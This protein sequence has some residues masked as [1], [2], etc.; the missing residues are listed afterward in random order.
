V[1]QIAYG[2]QVDQAA[3]KRK[4]VVVVSSDRTFAES[5]RSH[6]AREF[7]VL[8]ARDGGEAAAKAQVVPIDVAVV[9]LGAPLLGMSALSRMK[10]MA[11]APV[12]CALALP[13]APPAQAQFD[14]DY[15]LARPASGADLPERVRFILAK[16]ASKAEE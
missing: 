15:V 3:W 2:G 5:L 4:V 16:A 8:L 9:D 7:D 14:F 12:I 10:S 13:G 1:E 6:L 11:S